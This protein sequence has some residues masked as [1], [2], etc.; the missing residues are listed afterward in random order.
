M[1]D[2]E[3][4]EISVK[5]SAGIRNHFRL[6]VRFICLIAALL[7]L[8][9]IGGKDTL[10]ALVPALSSFVAVTSILAAKTIKPI[11][12]LGLIGALFAI[13]YSFGKRMT[14]KIFIGGTPF[15]H[16]RVRQGVIDGLP[17]DIQKVRNAVALISNAV[18]NKLPKE[19]K[20]SP[21]PPQD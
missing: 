14:L 17:I 2:N 11:L 18:A 5:K 13:H 16:I 21:P 10:M 4:S 3:L 1:S 12:I 8:L 19:P 9:P 6:L 20:V 15:V 7:C